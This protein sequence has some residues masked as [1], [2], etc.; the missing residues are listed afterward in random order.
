MLSGW[1][2]SRELI[3]FIWE[4]EF[5]FLLMSFAIFLYYVSLLTSLMISKSSQLG[6]PD[7]PNKNTGPVT[8][9]FHI[10]NEWFFVFLFFLVFFFSIYVACPKYIEVLLR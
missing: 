2:S 1:G 8:F 10:N 6:L 4:S 3:I 9:Q 7:F 5:S